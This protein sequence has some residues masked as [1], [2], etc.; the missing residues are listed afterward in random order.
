MA[1]IEIPVFSKIF[2]KDS[3][4][5]RILREVEGIRKVTATLLEEGRYTDALER[6]VEGLRTLHEFPD[7]DNVEFRALLV[8]LLFDLTE[9]Y[10]VLKDYKKAENILEILFKVLEFLLKADPERFGRFHILAMELS[11]RILRS[12]RKTMDLLVRQQMTTAALF[13]KVNS[14]MVAATDKLVESLRKV[15]QLLASSGDYRAAMKFYSE[16]IRMSKRRAGRITRKEIK[17]T[18]EMAEIM[19]RIRSM[20]PRAKRLLSA[21]LPHA[22]ALETIELEEDILALTEVIDADIEAEPRWK[23]FL[24][25]LSIP[26]R[27]LR[28]KA[29]SENPENSEDSEDSGHSVDSSEEKPGKKK[30]SFLKKKDKKEKKEKEEKKD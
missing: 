24:H 20:R 10:Y 27:G 6:T 12:R 22:I 15:A 30:K 14:G 7:Y 3:A 11:T 8:G 5:H 2:Q 9:V 1:H 13:D 26:V 21:V 17:M 16:A 29:E 19:M 25:K 23:N 4:E 28:R 18:I